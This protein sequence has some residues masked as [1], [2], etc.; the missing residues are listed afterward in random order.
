MILNLGS[1]FV[2]FFW[3][4]L[5]TPLTYLVLL[6]FRSKSKWV[7]GKLSS[8]SDSIRGNVMIR[9]LLEGALD[10]CICI[11]FQFEFSEWNNG[12]NFQTLF[13]GV[14][15]VM[16]VFFTAIMAMFIP[17]L[18]IFYLRRF[19]SWGDEQFE[20]RYGAV[21][22]GLRKDRKSSLGYP[23]IH[24]LRRFIFILVA[25]LAIDKVFV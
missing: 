6:P 16:T 3:L 9:Y 17:F 11:G 25:I 22:D 18:I 5:G 8:L 10:I 14:N 12:L 19:E 20:N 7:R 24:F 23:L 1:M 2:I 13:M 21:F 15:T 4:S